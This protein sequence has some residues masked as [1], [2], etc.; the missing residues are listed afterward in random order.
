MKEKDV[1][2]LYDL[3]L[4]YDDYKSS[5]NLISFNFEY[6][7]N[8][9]TPEIIENAK[10]LFLNLINNLLINPN[11]KLKEINILD[12]PSFDK[13]IYEM[14][15]TEKKFEEKTIQEFFEETVISKPNN[16]AMYDDNLNNF[17]TYDQLNKKSNQLANYLRNKFNILPETFISICLDY[18]FDLVISVL[19]IFNLFIFFFYFFIFF[20]KKVF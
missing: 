19:G 2:V 5:K 10:K 9:F 15:K 7:N 16:I 11:Q 4:F 3:G 6:N 20:L 1:D 18:S 14:N 13:Q 12:K 17:M 8:I